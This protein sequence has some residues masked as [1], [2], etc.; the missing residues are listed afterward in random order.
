M[1]QPTNSRLNAAT[2]LEEI[3]IRFEEG[4]P[5]H[6]YTSL[7]DGTTSIEPFLA[8]NKWQEAWRWRERVRR[9]EI[10]WALKPREC[11]D[12]GRRLRRTG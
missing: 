5:V 9:G 12:W 7:D 2:E 10:H 8:L 3:N 4:I 1:W 6:V 11:Y